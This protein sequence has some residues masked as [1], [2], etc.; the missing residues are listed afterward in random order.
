VLYDWTVAGAGQRI[1]A[2]TLLT[3]ATLSLISCSRQADVDKDADNKNAASPPVEAQSP[4]PPSA[5]QKIEGGAIEVTSTPVGASIMLIETGE[6]GAGP[7]KPRGVTPTTIGGLPPGKYVV[8]IE[9]PGY[10]FF[11]KKVE[12]KGNETVKVHARLRKS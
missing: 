1:R 11:Q 6:G 9:K 7:P 10:T 5:P 12:L 4:T 8:H 3:I 2:A